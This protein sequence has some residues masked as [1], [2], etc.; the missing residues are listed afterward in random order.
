MSNE[1]N[2]Y[3]ISPEE[4]RY[5]ELMPGVKS[6]ILTGLLGEKMMMVL[7]T[8]EPGETVPSHA[9]PHEQIGMVYSG[10]ASFR[11]GNEERE[12]SRNDFFSIPA[13]VDHEATCISAEP[14]VALDIF[15]P[16]REDMAEKAR[17]L[18]LPR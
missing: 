1:T 6:R 5:I 10:K 16:V 17:K 11:V 3:F 7:T 2:H 9:H 13:N 4:I 8:V 14:F 18:E 12:V 15:C